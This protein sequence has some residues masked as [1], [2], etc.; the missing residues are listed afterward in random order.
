LFDYETKQAREGY[1]IVPKTINKANEFLKMHGKAE[2][3]W[4]I[5]NI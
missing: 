1:T 3:N 5:E 2:I 4:K